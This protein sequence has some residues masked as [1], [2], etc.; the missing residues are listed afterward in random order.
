MEDFR[1]SDEETR[2]EPGQKHRQEK[3]DT[4]ISCNGKGCRNNPTK[5]SGN[6]TVIS[7]PMGG[8]KVMADG[9]FVDGQARKTFGLVLCCEQKWR[10][11]TL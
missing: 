2:C 6:T 10:R 5:P 4:T 3:H 7:L 8:G 1:C 9:T 11:W